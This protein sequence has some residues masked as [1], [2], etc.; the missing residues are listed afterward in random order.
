MWEKKLESDS[1]IRRFTDLHLHLVYIIRA[2]LVCWKWN[3]VK[4]AKQAQHTRYITASFLFLFFYIVSSYAIVE[5]EKCRVRDE[6]A[7]ATVDTR[8]IFV[9]DFF[10][11]LF[12]L[13]TKLFTLPFSKILNMFHHSNNRK[14]KSKS[15]LGISCLILHTLP[16]CVETL[17]NLLNRVCKICWVWSTALEMN[18]R[19]DFCDA[20]YCPFSM[21]WLGNNSRASN[22]H[23]LNEFVL[24]NRT[25]FALICFQADF[26]RYFQTFSSI[27][28]HICPLLSFN[29]NSKFSTCWRQIQF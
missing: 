21:L 15:L 26:A 24:T 27:H 19:M 18:G 25:G 14:S 13:S 3:E 16:C 6:I 20:V 8:Q 5:K 7:F 1:E 12:F 17:D 29:F 4:N 10:P 23:N 28:P 9:V 11:S 2:N 22:K